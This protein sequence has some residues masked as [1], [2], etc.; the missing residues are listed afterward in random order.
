MFATL[1][2]ALPAAIHIAVSVNLGYAVRLQD[3]PQEPR[4]L[5]IMG[6][7]FTAILA[8]VAMAM[9]MF[10]LL[11]IPVMAY[12]MAL[13]AFMLRWVGKRRPKEK[14]TSTILGALL[15][16]IVGLGTSA[17]VMILADIPPTAAT[18][19]AILRWPQIL[20]VDGII[21][22]WFTLNPLFNTA[23]GAQLGWRLGEILEQMAQYY[24]F[25]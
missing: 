7:V 17:L 22:L 16:L 25:W 11:A 19:G 4:T 13:V 5:S 15:G 21:L 14:L 8:V 23:A 9:V 12:G 6:I 18:Y 24:F 3:L 20:T 2:V 1:A 10:F